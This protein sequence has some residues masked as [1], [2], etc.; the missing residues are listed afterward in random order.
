MGK[1]FNDPL[2][3]SMVVVGLLG[4]VITGLSA[5]GAAVQNVIDAVHTGDPQQVVNAILTG[6]ATIIG[7]VLNGGYGPD[8]GPLVGSD[9]PVLAGGLFSLGGFDF[10]NGIVLNV[11]GPIGTLQTLA[12]QIANAL[13]PPAAVSAAAV[14][15]K[16]L[17]AASS[18]PRPRD[19]DAGQGR[20]GRYGHA[21]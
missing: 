16:A 14:H 19:D 2:Y 20:R 3:D 8:L 18:R 21:E 15:T 9:F 12:Q 10:S 6:P 7:G 1:V 5:T 13:K 11:A 17:P 4:P